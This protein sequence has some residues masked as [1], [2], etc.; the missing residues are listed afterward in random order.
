YTVEVAVDGNEAWEQLQSQPFD[1]VV[2]DIEMPELDGF[3][4]TER[5]KQSTQF[6]NLP[7][8]IVTSLAKETDKQRGIEVGADAYIVKQQFETRALLDVIGQFV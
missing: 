6:A 7:V 5:I 3:E 1:L 2:T 8:V 4:L